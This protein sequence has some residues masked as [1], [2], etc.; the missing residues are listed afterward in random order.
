MQTLD[1]LGT[2]DH[3]SSETISAIASALAKAAQK[4][5]PSKNSL[6]SVD[7]A[8]LVAGFKAK[9]MSFGDRVR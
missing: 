6:N 3:R 4:S 1:Q 5:I 2:A 9:L 8:S 7:A